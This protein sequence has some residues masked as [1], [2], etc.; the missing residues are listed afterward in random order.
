L[1]V[2]SAWLSADRRVS[3]LLL[4]PEA[5][6]AIA[7]AQRIGRLGGSALLRAERRVEALWAA[8][9]RLEMTEELARRAGGFAQTHGL[10]AYDAVHLASAVSVADDDVVLVAADRELV[11][12]AQMIGI[13]SVPL[14]E[15]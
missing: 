6:A 3:S 11:A 5:C 15:S 12:A 7:R 2:A 9:D 13:A 14:S 10:R 4:Y 8:V 1:Q